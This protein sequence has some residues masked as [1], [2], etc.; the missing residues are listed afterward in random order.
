[1]N[2]IAPAAGY[3]FAKQEE[4]ET[5]TASGILLAQGQADKPKIA[6][7]INVGE[8]ITY[9]K[10]KDR[11]VYKSYTT[12]DI[13]LD[14]KDYILVAVEDVLGKIVEVNG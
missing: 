4:A 3:L 1:M 7:V 13:K 11:I 2:T 5:K 10:A 14:N 6:E 12:T 9:Y 8:G